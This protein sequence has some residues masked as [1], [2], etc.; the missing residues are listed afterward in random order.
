MKKI[1]SASFG[2][3]NYRFPYWYLYLKDLGIYF[4]RLRY[5]IK[6]GYYPQA[7]W[8]SYSYFIQ[9]WREILTGYRWR[10]AGSACIVTPVRNDPEWEQENSK[11][12]DDLLDTM[13]DDLDI[14]EL[15]PIDDFE[16]Y[17]EVSAKRDE[18][19]KDFFEKFNRIFYDLWD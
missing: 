3:F 9:M 1:T 16:H 13:L 7:Q 6:Y 11:A 4:K 14:M 8:E 15:D 19:T 12:L 10:R 5:V 18:A 2:L 17:Q